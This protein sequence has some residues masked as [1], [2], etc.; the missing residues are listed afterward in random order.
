[1]TYLNLTTKLGRSLFEPGRSV[2]TDHLTFGSRISSLKK[3]LT[4]ICLRPKAA[5]MLNGERIPEMSRHS[6]VDGRGEQGCS[7]GRLKLFRILVF[8]QHRCGQPQH[9]AVF[10]SC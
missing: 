10:P 9:V 8:Q 7:D 4:F 2:I 5:A 3:A 6:E 1:M